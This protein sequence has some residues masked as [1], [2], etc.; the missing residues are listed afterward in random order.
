MTNY[1]V[2]WKYKPLL[3]LVDLTGN[4]IFFY[5][6]I[7][8]K[9]FKKEDVKKILI[10]RVDE[11]GDVVLTTPLISTLKMEFPKA[12]VCILVKKS[13]AE[14]LKH[15]PNVD[16]IYITKSW[17]KEKISL[18]EFIELIK[19]L[20][21][22]NFDLVFDP[23][24]DP[25]DIILAYFVGKYKVGY[26]VR[27]FSFLLDS[28]AEYKNKHIMETILDLARIL[29]VKKINNK[30]EVYFSKKDEMKI[31]NLFKRYKLKR[32]K[33]L[34]CI[35]P[36]TGR[37]NK[38]WPLENWQNLTK[39][40]IKKYNCQVIFTGNAGD[41]IL[42][43][44]IIKNNGNC[45]NFAGKTTLLELAALI[46][47]CDLF[48]APDTGSLHIARALNIPL[49]GLFGPVDPKIW[50]YDEE[51]YRSI[52]K[53]PDCSFCNMPT[54]KRK[55]EKNECMTDISVADVFKEIDGLIK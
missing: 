39:L 34:I 27:G 49:I 12:K 44:K 52:Y 15:N 46:K 53:K 40:L 21:K 7:F 35:N 18:G 11:I 55:L 13:T 50:G 29:G 16:E 30:M 9:R 31:N 3:F 19:K 47:I 24:A 8:K 17:F 48:I 25:R 10:I 23:H 43:D 26:N 33:L 54:C 1:Q 20:R 22:E 2:S 32:N 51:K 38:E 41:S 37:K 4:T 5:K 36:G 14:L 45:H 28:V 42:I 6:K